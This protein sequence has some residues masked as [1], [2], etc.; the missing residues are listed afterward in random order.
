ML[1]AK[2]DRKDFTTS[3]VGFCLSLFFGELLLIK[4]SWAPT[5]A[6]RKVRSTNN[7]GRVVAAWFGP[8]KE[9]A[10]SRG[11]RGPRGIPKTPAESG[12]VELGFLEGF[13]WRVS[14][15]S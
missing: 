3:L 2:K 8:F 14:V 11:P 12:A 4:N 7:R 9:V 5:T 10:R 6:I 13:L 1:T 15:S